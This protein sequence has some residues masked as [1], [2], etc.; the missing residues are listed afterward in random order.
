MSPPLT[1]SHL[2]ST[3][4]DPSTQSNR[5]DIS[6]SKKILPTA[7][8]LPNPSFNKLILDKI[9]YQKP[10]ILTSFS[11]DDQRQFLSGNQKFHSLKAF[12]TDL[13]PI[14]FDL[15]Q[16]ISD[17]ILRDLSFDQGID[18]ILLG[19]YDFLETS[20][21]DNRLQLY[22]RICQTQII[23]WRGLMAKLSSSI[24]ESS[25][26][27]TWQM[28]VMLVN[29]TIY[30]EDAFEFPKPPE[31][32]IPTYYG[33]SY[34]T[35]MTNKKFQNV[36]TNSEWGCIVKTNLNGI[37]IILSGEVDCVR[38]EALDAIQGKP[39]STTNIDPIEFIEIKNVSKLTND[40]QRWTMHRF[41]MLK[42]WL[43]SFLLGTPLVHVG[44]RDQE[45][46]VCE[47]TSYKTEEI[48]KIV[49]RDCAPAGRW[50][51]TLCLENGFKILSFL[52]NHLNPNQ[53]DQ[54]KFYE[55]QLQSICLS[56]S[57]SQDE[58]IDSFDFNQWKLWPVYR[59]KFTC[60]NRQRTQPSQIELIQLDYEN[61]ILNQV[62]SHKS[63]NE[64]RIGFLPIWWIK[65]QIKMKTALMKK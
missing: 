58:I 34:E 2:L 43:Q 36:N 55:D 64:Q 10:L 1:I 15:N 21:L 61:E 25:S 35:L 54:L 4:S 45:G 14:G 33:Y 27:E 46:I 23:T 26:S 41:K 16:S 60:G 20:D 50:S 3:H 62:Q 32:I 24:Y 56:Q 28:N 19:L 31:P 11:F 51:A 5:V 38:P 29:G 59:L 12:Q 42:F 47:T 17:L 9:S 63:Q 57:N 6:T 48:P 18:P 65:F 22:R 30:I 49:K 53:N 44:F 39:P 40:R 7:F 37:K 13:N 52:I 8:I